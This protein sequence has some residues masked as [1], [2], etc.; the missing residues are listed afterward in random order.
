MIFLNP[1]LIIITNSKHIR[2]Q[3]E[4]GL[5]KA[6]LKFMNWQAKN[7]RAKRQVF[8]KY[9]SEFRL[10]LA[11]DKRLRLNLFKLNKLLSVKKAH[12]FIKTMNFAYNYRLWRCCTVSGT[13]TTCIP[14]PVYLCVWR[15]YRRIPPWVSNFRRRQQQILSLKGK[16]R[17]RVQKEQKEL[18]DFI[19]S[20]R[21]RIQVF[22]CKCRKEFFVRFVSP[23]QFF[24]L[25]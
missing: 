17:Q 20:Y 4:I 9:F 14:G 1:K 11:L 7:F 6:Y 15:G 21:N 22:K 16:I 23:N 2:N 12:I 19:F 5:S 10:N 24:T 13:G 8:S 3:A 18:K 25:Q